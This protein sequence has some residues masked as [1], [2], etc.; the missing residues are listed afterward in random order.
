MLELD[1]DVII[2][3]MVDEY[4][5]WVEHALQNLEAA[6]TLA[7]SK[8]AHKQGANIVLNCQIALEKL[9][10]AYFI[11]ENPVKRHPREHSL[12][13]FLKVNKYKAEIP[14]PVFEICKTLDGLYME[15]RYPDSNLHPIFSERK[16]IDDI[17]RNTRG[18]VTWLLSQM[19]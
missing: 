4:K 14:T 15:S 9:L 13:Y 1:C 16:F 17:L 19:K 7:E 6:D 8:V 10:K 18:A 11:K 5:L 12:L 2:S 3:A